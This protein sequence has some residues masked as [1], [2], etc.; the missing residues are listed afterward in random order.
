M[1]RSLSAG[2]DAAEAATERALTELWQTDELRASPITVPE[3]ARNAL[4]FFERSIF[5]TVAWL[6]DDLRAALSGAYPNHEFNVGPFVTYR[7]WVG[8]DRDGNP[9][10]TPDVTWRTLLEHRRL[11]LEFFIHRV[12]ALRR[13]LTLGL[14]NV[15]PGDALLQSLETDCAH[16][17]LPQERQNR[18]KAE[19]YALKLLFI[20]QRLQETLHQ[21]PAPVGT[22]EGAVSTNC[23]YKSAKAFVDDLLLLQQSLRDNRAERLA[24]GGSF[25]ALV[26]QAQ[27]FGFHLAALDVRQHSDEHARAL[28]EILR[29]SGVLDKDAP[30][31]GDLPEAE[32][33]ELLT[34]ELRNPRPLVARDAPLSDAT[35][36]VVQVFDVIRR[37][38][39]QLS[40]ESVTAY[41]IS[42]THQVSDMLEPMLFAKEA[43][44]LR[45]ERK[46]R[47]GV[48][49]RHRAA[50]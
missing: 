19:P 23:A 16:V 26:V 34:R 13:E 6:H 5:D 50:F 48:R 42:M 11:A 8:G 31:Y 4:Y 21:M 38:R 7:S 43:G 35:Q 37:A 47:H 49:T 14:R 22:S 39:R 28:D 20:N 1:D 25:A 27:T 30:A 29:A 32:K 9:N 24:N 18:Y 36:N 40:P 41:I 15:A 44:L 46:R 12:D 10:V 3:E 33:L 45:W 17:P 2:E